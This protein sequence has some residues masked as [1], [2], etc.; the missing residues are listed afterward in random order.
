MYA[1]AARVE[2]VTPRWD[3]RYMPTVMSAVPT[4]GKTLY[5]PQRLIRTPDSIEVSSSPAIS[6]S[7]CR[8]SRWDWRL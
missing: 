7:S 2:V 8:P 3:S 4:I 6:G 1:E 5:R